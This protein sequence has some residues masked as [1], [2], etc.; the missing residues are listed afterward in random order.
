[1]LTTTEVGD[2]GEVSTT[3]VAFIM[4]GATK[5]TAEGT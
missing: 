2:E 4:L 1:M 3:L 5:A